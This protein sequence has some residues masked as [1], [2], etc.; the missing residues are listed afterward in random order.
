M[1]LFLIIV[2]SIFALLGIC[3]FMDLIATGKEVKYPERFEDWT[4]KDQQINNGRLVS[5]AM[6]FTLT[7]ILGLAP[8]LLG[9]I[10]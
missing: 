5:F 3:G 9:I 1:K 10:I 2:G 6:S 4:Q 8:I 7:F